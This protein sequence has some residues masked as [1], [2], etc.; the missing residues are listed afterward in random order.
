VT[1]RSAY[2]FDRQRILVADEDPVTCEMIVS[3]LREE[4]Y[5]VSLEPAAL[6]ADHLLADSQL[7]ISSL[8][9]AGAVR[10]DLLESVRA[11]RPTLPILF[12]A[13]EGPLPHDLPSLSI[14]CT[15]AELRAAVRRVLPALETAPASHAPSP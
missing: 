6:S 10:R 11:S 3:V 14:P 8:R 13:R 7:L 1:P 9:V 15:P 2:V 4:G 12:L 5:C